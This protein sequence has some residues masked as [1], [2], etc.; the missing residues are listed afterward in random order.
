MRFRNMELD[1]D[2]FDAEAAEAY[3]AALERVASLARGPAE[4]RLSESIRR[5]CALVFD[6]FDEL[7]GE[8]FHRRIFGGRANLT[9]C[10]DA[11]EEFASAAD[12]QRETLDKRLLALRAKDTRA[13]RRSASPPRG[14][15]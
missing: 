14:D 8:G 3:E 9:D 13:A 4:E 15:R 2:L 6:F 1:F 11:F 10:L 7:F 5:Q 12:A